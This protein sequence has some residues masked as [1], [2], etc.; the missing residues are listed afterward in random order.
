MIRIEI[1]MHGNLRRFLPD[2]VSSVEL[3]L[4]DDTRVCDAIH[5]VGTL[6]DTGVSSSD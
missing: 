4:P 6:A 2:G 3:D 5:L 1:H